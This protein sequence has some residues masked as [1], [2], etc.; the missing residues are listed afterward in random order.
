MILTEFDLMALISKWAIY[1]SFASL[2]GGT[3]MLGLLRDQHSEAVAIRRYIFI[4]TCLGVI[5][6]VINFFAQVGA[7]AESGFAGMFDTQMRQFLWS[8]PIGES[9]TWRIIG[10]S[11][12]L[13]ACGSVLG[14][15]NALRRVAWIGLLVGGLILATS[16]SLLGHS[17]E[18]NR[19]AQGMLLLH[20][21][22]IG[23]WVGSFYPLWR[24]CAH[25][26]L[27]LIRHVM[28][29]FGQLG[30]GIVILVSG[31][32]GALLWQL[33]D[34]PAEFFSSNYG[35]A[36]SLKLSFFCIILLIA[37]LHKF[38]LVPRLKI[39]NTQIALR[40][41]KLSIAIE[42]LVALFILTITAVLSSVFGP[43]SLS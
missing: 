14:P 38:I 7:F 19:F 3:L 13:I 9:V 21:L 12:V 25:A 39:A 1:V 4:G 2:I 40:K 10:F 20:V 26:D 43:E 23:S 30:I 35:L 17:A 42:G 8:S 31:S 24:L 6:V 22:A 36:I 41:L 27:T 32:G 18:L 29:K 34:K 15:V 5:A 33:F 28:D 11:I 16:F 37:A